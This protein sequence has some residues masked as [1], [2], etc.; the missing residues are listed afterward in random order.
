MMA[1][2]AMTGSAASG[3]VADM[4]IGVWGQRPQPPEAY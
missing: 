4:Q 2:S 1:T 3:V